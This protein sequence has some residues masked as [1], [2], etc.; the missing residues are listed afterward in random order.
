M[1]NK[2]TYPLY[3]HY[4]SR[5]WGGIA[6]SREPYSNRSD[7]HTEIIWKKAFVKYPD[8]FLVEEVEVDFNPINASYAYLLTVIY[9]SGDTFGHSYGNWKAIGAFKTLEEA[10]SLKKQI[11]HD[12]YHPKEPKQYKGYAIWNGY[13]ETFTSANIEVID[14]V[15]E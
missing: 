7:S 3:F 6:E 12:A 5:E 13:F 4:V 9:E 2:K 14:I 1:K 15:K 10:A 8:C 11:E